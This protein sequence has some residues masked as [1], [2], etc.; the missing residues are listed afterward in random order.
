MRN[1]VLGVFALTL[2]ACAADVE[3]ATPRV[4]STRQALSDD[5]FA[6]ILR[7]DSS[8]GDMYHDDFNASLGV[9][10]NGSSRVT[11]WA[12]Q[13]GDGDAFPDVLETDRRDPTFAEYTQTK[14]VYSTTSFGGAPGVTSDHWAEQLGATLT[15]P[16]PSGNRPYMWI[17]I[18][19]A[20][21]NPTYDLYLSS[22]FDTQNGDWPVSEIE[23]A[24]SIDGSLKWD[25]WRG[26]DSDPS[27][28]STCGWSQILQGSPTSAKHLVEIGFTTSGTAALV[29]DGTA[30]NSDTGGAA[31][32]D[33][34][35]L[36]LFGSPESSIGL[37]VTIARMIVASNQPSASQL[38]AM[39][40][41]FVSTYGVTLN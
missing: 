40:S 2:A 23:I 21:F 31:S 32:L 1:L 27:C 28:S 37:K 13:T 12:N 18:D 14:P 16:I 4:A 34:A 9:S 5:P 8:R 7:N 29:V 20:Q 3:K 41:Q 17:V 38:S 30:Y 19:G 33:M 24:T 39:R 10:V 6:V 26:D 25:M 15:S 22:L 35:G 36:W 11:Q